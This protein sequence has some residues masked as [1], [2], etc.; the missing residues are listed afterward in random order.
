[1]YAERPESFL[2]L[3]KEHK[4][5]QIEK[6]WQQPGKR[7]FRGITEDDKK[8]IVN[9]VR[10]FVGQRYPYKDLVL[11]LLDRIFLNTYFFRQFQSE[12]SRICSRLWAEGFALRNFNYGGDPKKI[13]PDDMHDFVRA[14]EG[15]YY[16]KIFPMGNLT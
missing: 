12:L 9:Y 10:T 1:M 4:I 13:N 3:D 6:E 15:K 16:E 14:T 5:Y 8:F 7:C 11:H 2:W